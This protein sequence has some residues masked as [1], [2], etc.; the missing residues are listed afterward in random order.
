MCT[1]YRPPLPPG[2][3][4][5]EREPAARMGNG[6]ALTPALSRRERGQGRQFAATGVSLI[7]AVL[8]MVVVSVA[9]VVL[10]KAFNQAAVASADPILRRQSLAIAQSLLEEISYKDFANPTPGGY[11]GPYNATTRSQFDDVMDYNGLTLNGISDLSGTALAGL[12]GYRA[13]IT[14]AA[15]AF[16]NVPSSAGWRITVTVTDPAGQQLALEGYRANY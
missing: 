10:V 4:L 14:V 15:A 3:G 13:G 16:G 7:E 5:G 12:S 2:E 11:A 6:R 8:F 9:L 1:D